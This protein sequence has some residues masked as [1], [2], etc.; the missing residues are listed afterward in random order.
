MNFS[1]E[2]VVKKILPHLFFNR[3]GD[4]LF[5]SAKKYIEQSGTD[6]D[7]I[8][9]E[10]NGLD[11]A[12]ETFWEKNIEILSI[13]Y[14]KEINKQTLMELLKIDTDKFFERLLS[15]RFEYEFVSD[16]EILLADIGSFDTF[17]AEHLESKDNLIIK[18]DSTTLI[19][20]V[21]SKSEKTYVKP[22]Q[23]GELKFYPVSLI[24]VDREN[25]KILLNGSKIDRTHLISQ[26]NDFDENVISK[27]NVD[28]LLSFNFDISQ[29]FHI[30][31]DKGFYLKNVK[32]HG[33]FFNL[34]L[35]MTGNNVLEISE[36]INPE[37]ILCDISDFI[38][39]KQMKFDY[40]FDGEKNISFNLVVETYHQKREGV[41]EKYFKII[42]KI[43]SRRK[44]IDLPKIE[45]SIIEELN[46]IG[47]EINKAYNMPNSYYFDNF[48]NAKDDSRSKYLEIL[49]ENPESK[50]IINKLFENG[51]LS[52]DGAEFDYDKYLKVLSEIL[53]SLKGERTKVKDESFEILEINKKKTSIRLRVKI[54]SDVK[55][56]KYTDYYSVIIPFG[57]RLKKMDKIH[58]IILSDLNI[59][60]ILLNHEDY[61]T[62]VLNEVYSKVKIYLLYHYK[63]L[64]GKEANI[65][66]YWLVKYSDNPFEFKDAETPT[67]SGYTVEHNINVLLKFLFGNYLAI[68]GRNKP[69]GFLGFEGDIAYVIDSKQHQKLEKGE[70][71]KLRDYTH[72][73]R[74]EE[75]LYDIK[76]GVLIICKKI[77]ENGS[78]NPSSREE[79]LKDTDAIIGYLSLEFLLELYELYSKYF[80]SDLDVRTRLRATT[81][82]VIEKSSELTNVTDLEKIEKEQI[83]KLSAEIE[84]SSASSIPKKVE[85][86]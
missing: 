3:K 52:K 24:K 7:N 86:L 8:I 51:V 6:I 16:D 48:V 85:L 46:T 76:G 11:L 37:L 63:Q 53:R 50:L 74:T 38:K 81:L 75:N 31:R 67:K 28:E 45:Q 5:D 55:E 12:D 47:I 19:F 33:S 10:L 41:D 29:L 80:N 79:V 56:K 25:K 57:S 17:L 73:Y 15:L 65:S 22:F 32:F 30:M 36:F 20:L 35:S 13:V 83:G 18:D 78:L 68:G 1:K 72:S 43:T 23:P 49:R 9:Q 39:L 14:E 26:I 42:L 64:L 58:N 70:F 69:D 40:Y 60:K 59:Y 4:R 66:H 71:A 61:P 77:L 62:E 21:D 54:Y 27:E 2:I 84:K 82:K 44:D 34:N